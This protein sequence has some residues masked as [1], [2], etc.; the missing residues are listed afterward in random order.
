M[1][2]LR[3][4]IVVVGDLKPV[5]RGEYVQMERILAIGLVIHTI[6]DSLI[7]PLVVECGGL[8]R[9]QKPSRPQA[10]ESDEVPEFRGSEAEPGAAADAA[11]RAIIG[12]D[13]SEEPS[14]P[15]TRSS[16]DLRHQ[17]GLVSKFDIRRS[18]GHLHALDSVDW[19]LRGK[20]LALLIADQLP[21][22]EEA[23]LG[24]VA[25]RVKEPIAIGSDTAGAVDD[26]LA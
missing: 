19:K 11:E 20:Q 2:V 16:S 21:V 9:I 12:I 4:L 26:G 6:E 22:N 14:R 25:Q 5:P 24:V 17:T 18:G 23:R 3:Q 7:V 13:I 1:L 8:R 10:V 15:Q